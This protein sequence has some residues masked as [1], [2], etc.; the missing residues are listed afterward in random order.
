MTI[1]GK[2][3]SLA[4]VTPIWLEIEVLL[5][6]YLKCVLY[7]E[8]SRSANFKA[9]LLI[10]SQSELKILSKYK[11]M[12]CK[13]HDLKNYLSIRYIYYGFCT[14]VWQAGKSLCC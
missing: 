1:Y 14:W 13:C 9:A 7:R 3:V 11:Q 4:P 10:L 5:C 6:L 12:I 8:K 2:R